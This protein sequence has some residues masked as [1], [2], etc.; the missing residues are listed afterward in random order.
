MAGRIGP[1]WGGGQV[2]VP[3]DAGHLADWRG[4]VPALGS[5]DIPPP[6]ESRGE[7]PQARPLD[8]S[9]DIFGHAFEV[10]SKERLL[11][12]PLHGLIAVDEGS[13]DGRL[14]VRLIDAAEVQRLRRIRQLG[15]AHYAFQGAEHSRFTHSV[16]ALHLMGRLL[17]QLSRGY[18]IDSELA[19]YARVAALL[20]DIGHGPF[21]HVSERI[22]GRRHEEWTL[23]ILHDD[24]TGVHRALSGYSRSLPSVIESMI[25]G[26]A[27][28]GY[29]CSLVS[30]QLD[31]DRLDYLLRDSLMTGVKYGI[32]DLDRLMHM[33]RIS[34][35][36]DKIIVAEGGIIPVEKYIQARYHMYRQVYLHKTV[37][38]AEAMLA[39]LLRRA[40]ELLQ[41]G[42]DAG[43][44]PDSAFGRALTAP[45][46]LALQDFLELDD[47]ECWAHIKRW[48]RA[49]D[50]ILGDLSRRMLTRR[51][52]KTLEINAALPDAA[53]RIDRARAAVETAGLD[54]RYYFLRADSTDTPYTPYDLAAPRA[55]DHI[56][57]EDGK[58]GIVDV[59]M[60]SPT[61]EVFTKSKYTLSR[62]VFPERHAEVDL[63]AQIR[64]A[65]DAPSQSPLP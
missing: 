32:F 14:L 36:G 44:D 31:V 46:D 54:P 61:I 24:A 25:R 64:A 13:A 37:T 19:F 2:C 22:L 39:A 60:L 59:A 15:L 5:R 9:P 17:E 50:P 3:G 48:T 40:G 38:A 21:S 42:Q 49:A 58:G 4:G 27:K 30:S 63:R 8:S 26:M 10:R 11:R 65:F 35:A 51:L 20:H 18:T 43:M 23:R 55:A 29:L 12:D 56:F 45:E 47:V 16:G 52:F 33:L 6:R 62:L 1:G 7:V 34:P 53:A 28:P 57:I 41:Q